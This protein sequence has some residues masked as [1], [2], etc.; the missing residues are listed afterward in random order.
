[1]ADHCIAKRSGNSDLKLTALRGRLGALGIP[2]EFAGEGVLVCG[3]FAEGPEADD[4]VAVRKLGRGRV[5]IEGGVS[6]VYYSVRREI[7]AL[8]AIVAT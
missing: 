5:M 7:Y 2:A 8:H 4:V 3:A 6:D 1:M